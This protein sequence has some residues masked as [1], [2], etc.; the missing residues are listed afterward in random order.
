MRPHTL[1]TALLADGVALLMFVVAHVLVQSA[2]DEDF[3][4]QPGA[5]ILLA[6]S[7]AIFICSAL[8]A[9]TDLV[10]EPLTTHWGRWAIRGLWVFVWLL[11]AGTSLAIG[12]HAS[13]HQISEAVGQWLELLLLVLAGLTTFL[14]AIS[15]EEGKRGWLVVPVLLGAVAASFVAGEVFIQN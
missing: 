4:D 14:G 15:G 5:V 13:G 2:T 10:S 7:A 11:I 3:F 12:I 1:S 9:L 8:L 6:C